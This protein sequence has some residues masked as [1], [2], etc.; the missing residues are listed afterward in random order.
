MMSSPV[1]TGDLSALADTI[2]GIAINKTTLQNNV[3][4]KVRMLR[5]FFA[6]RKQRDNYNPVNDKGNHTQPN[7]L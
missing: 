6:P 1:C 7:W 3:V 4:F 5:M 2:F